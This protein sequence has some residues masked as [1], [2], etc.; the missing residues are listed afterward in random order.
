MVFHGIFFTVKRGCRQGDPI[1]AY[2]FILCAEILNVKLKNNKNIKGIHINN[3]GYIIS[4]FADDITLFLDGSDKSLRSTLKLLEEFSRISGLSVN[5]KKLIWIGS[6]KH[7]TRS[8]KTKW[9]LSW[10]EIQFKILGITFHVNLRN[11]VKINFEPK[12]QSIKNSIA[13]WNRRK[14]TTFGKITVVKSILVPTL[15][16]LF[17]GLPSPTK[18]YIKQISGNLYNFVWDGACKKKQFL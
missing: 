16:H 5:L 14:L 13:F 9:K 17:L 11:M 3:K 7:S 4:Q 18:E 1:S 2:I 10:G 12:I 6:M 15:T 8:I